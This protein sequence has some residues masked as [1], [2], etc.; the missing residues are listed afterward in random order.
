MGAKPS[1]RARCSLLDGPSGIIK[2][3]VVGL[4]PGGNV[5]APMQVVG[6]G[7]EKQGQAR[8]EILCKPEV[9][10]I[11]PST[12]VGNLIE[13]MM[14]HEVLIVADAS[15]EACVMSCRKREWEDSL[16]EV[17]KRIGGGGS[18]VGGFR[19]R[20]PPGKQPLKP[21]LGGFRQRNPPV[22]PQLAY[23]NRG[24]QEI[25]PNATLEASPAGNRKK[26][27]S[28][29]G[30]GGTTKKTPSSQPM[31]GTLDSIGSMEDIAD[32]NVT[33]EEEMET[34]Q[35]EKEVDDQNKEFGD[36]EHDSSKDDDTDDVIPKSINKPQGSEFLES[37]TMNK[38]MMPPLIPLC[39]CV[40]NEKVRELRWDL[41]LLKRVLEDDGYF[42]MKGS[43]ILS[44][45]M[46]D[47]TTKD[48][49]DNIMKTWDKNWCLVNKE[50]EEELKTDAKWSIL[51]NKMFL[52]NE[53]AIVK[54]NLKDHLY[55]TSTL[56][57]CDEA[58]FIG[59]FDETEKMSITRARA[60]EV[61][62]GKRVWYP[63][64]QP[65]LGRLVYGGKWKKDFELAC[66]KISL[67]LPKED[68]LR[69][70]IM[71]RRNV[72]K[73][74]NRKM[75][76][77]LS[78]VNPANGVEWF[79]ILW[80]LPFEDERYKISIEKLY[81]VSS[82][83]CSTELKLR[84]L[85]MLGQDENFCLSYGM[86]LG[87]HHYIPWLAKEGWMDQL[88]DNATRLLQQV[89][90][91]TTGPNKMELPIGE[92]LNAYFSD[93]VN[94]YRGVLFFSF[95][96]EMNVGTTASKHVDLKNRKQTC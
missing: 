86:P 78:V 5:G 53:E 30:K 79:E 74:Y 66:S 21:V 26:M 89:L 82:A 2:G 13:K 77:N 9:V 48:V 19:Q 93:I 43:F 76:R 83:S 25:P 92:S 37:I 47:G 71:A 69:A 24:V 7:Q 62:S 41:S 8:G 87:D 3:V 65:I 11:A 96:K 36:R 35:E 4:L 64:T 44:I 70:T 88:L 90:D 58:Q 91:S 17:V 31:E 10:N 56:C 29:R 15:L 12:R 49:D 51:S 80:K 39:R 72:I 38:G 81:S 52:M 16:G 63:L 42:V 50:F 23:G 73:A 32:V 54:T 57:A 1:N 75:T 55:H 46:P 20:N 67:N 14:K 68:Q 34:Q 95:Q 84:M 28:T 40:V 60:Q 22:P 18:S 45:A 6:M 85:K 33:F 27:T 94:R 61:S 59:E